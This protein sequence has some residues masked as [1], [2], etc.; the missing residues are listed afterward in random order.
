MNSSFFRRHRHFILNV[1]SSSGLLA[2][3]DFCA[4]IF[5]DK[6]ES[7]DNKRL[8]KNFLLV[9]LS[10]HF[11]FSSCSMYYWNYHGYSRTYLV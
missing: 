5:Y 3:G 8:C 1:T 7:L 4:Q 6:K 10:N 9:V 11:S 2:L